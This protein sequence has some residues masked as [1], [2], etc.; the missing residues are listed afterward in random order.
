MSGNCLMPSLQW[1]LLPARRL[2]GT[3][4]YGEC[5]VPDVLLASSTQGHYDDDGSKGPEATP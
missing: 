2:Q 1:H 4:G 5:P 3:V